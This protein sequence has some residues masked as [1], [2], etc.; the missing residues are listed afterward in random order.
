M[1]WLANVNP[2]FSPYL[3]LFDDTTWKK[4]RPTGR[5]C[6]AS[7]NSLPTQPPFGPEGANLLEMLR[8]PALA[9]PQLA[10]GPARLHHGE[11]GPSARQYF[12]RLLGGQDLIKEEEKGGLPAAGPA[13]VYQF[14]GQEL[15]AERFSPD[16][17]W[18]P[19]LVLLAK[20]LY[21]WLDQLTQAISPPDPPAGSGPRR[22]TRPAGALGIL[23]AVADRP[24]GT[25][26]GVAKDQTALRQPRGGGLGLF[27]V[28]LPDRRRPGRRRGVPAL[29]E[30][31]W[32]RGIR[33]ASDMV[34]NHM[35]IDSRW[36]IEHPDWFISLDQSPFPSYSLQRAGPVHRCARGHLPGGP[37]LLA[38]RRG[39][40]LQAAGPADRQREVRLSRQRRHQHA[41]ERHGPAEL[42]RPPGARGGHSDHPRRG[43]PS[44]PSSVSTPP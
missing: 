36:V 12:Y 42:P 43:P 18:M 29:K 21:V 32:R 23:R 31:A 24:V 27:A 41:L 40:G 28:R 2:A 17:D 14:A 25:Q 15:E 20:N 10:V 3:E 26:P 34:P 30:R 38:L 13:L 39:R 5:S 44:S 4:S 22:G 6:P 16:R 35:G 8:S 7:T 37:L 1:L 9:V 11:M 19:S 33:L